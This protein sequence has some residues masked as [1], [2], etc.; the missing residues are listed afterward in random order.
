MRRK[1]VGVPL[2]AWSPGR[3]VFETAARP[4]AL[5]RLSARSARHTTGNA[6]STCLD[7]VDSI[8]GTTSGV[9]NDKG[10]QGLR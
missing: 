10:S 4:T 2:P 9:A 5:Q 7:R 1:K 6:A 3:A 8:Q